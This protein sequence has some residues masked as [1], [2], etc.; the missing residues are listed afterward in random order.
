[1]WILFVACL[2]AALAAG[3]F[4]WRGINHAEVIVE[5]T[6]ASE[7]DT[8]GFNVYR[9]DTKDGQYQLV[10][11]SLIPG[12]SDPLTGGSY[13][14]RDSDVKP[15]GTYYYQLEDIELDGSSN[16]FGP[17]EVKAQAG[18]ISELVLAIALFFFG[19][20]GIQV[21]RNKRK[22]AGIA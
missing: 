10:N 5:W 16:S 1:M 9:S 3:F 21:L 2:P 17:I 20:A 6:T 13:T 4:A 8:V 19:I 15:G 14:Y 18:G 7:L 11:E 22:P 12:S